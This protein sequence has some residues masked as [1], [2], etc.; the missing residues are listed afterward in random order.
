M[1]TPILEYASVFERTL[2]DDSDVVQKELYA[3]MDKSNHKVIMRPEGTAPVMRAVISNAWSRHFPLGV[4]Y[5]GPMFRYENPQKGR[6]RQFEQFGVEMLS[7][8]SSAHVD[9]EVIEMAWETIKELGLSDLVTIEINTL[10][11]IES[12][13]AYR[14]HFLEYLQ[15]VKSHL[16]KDSLNRL[17]RGSIL[18][19]LDSKDVQDRR[20]FQNQPPP[21]LL[22]SL[23]PPAKERFDAL[24]ANLRLLDIPFKVNER[25]VRGL[26]YYSHSIFEFLGPDGKAVLAGGRYDGFMEHMLSLNGTKSKE[27][28]DSVGWAMGIERII[29][30]MEEHSIEFSGNLTNA[31]LLLIIVPSEKEEEHNKLIEYASQLASSLRRQN[32]QLIWSSEMAH[33]APSIRKQM[34]RLTKRSPV[35][36]E[37]ALFIGVDELKNG[38]VQVKDL[39]TGNQEAVSA[40]ELINR[41]R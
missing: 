41:I 11:D 1:S 20:L 28:T 37:Q 27:T 13:Q 5:H 40:H 30:V 26:D 12:R 38:T 22:D 25:L 9:A 34:N 21:S 33:E 29:A 24:R 3:F 16:S 2:G 14:T 23:T 19:I 17:E 8:G 36:P 4:Y 32:F 6:M 10:G 31:P 7:R 39:Q 18:R 15:K 35:H